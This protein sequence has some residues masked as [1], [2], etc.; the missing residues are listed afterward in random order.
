MHHHHNEDIEDYDRYR[1]WKHEHGYG[2]DDESDLV[3]DEF[4]REE[5]HKR[6]HELHH[7]PAEEHPVEEPEIVP[8]P[9][10]EPEPE[11]EPD[12][13]EDAFNRDPLCE[14]KFGWWRGLVEPLN[15]N[16]KSIEK[17]KQEKAEER[18][19][20]INNSINQ[21]FFDNKYKKYDRGA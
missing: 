7:M 11:S 19:E 13:Y 9:E 17:I 20:A 8:E 18:K 21:N 12:P 3:M 5:R 14:K 6:E 15:P 2:E 10:P 4:E 16:F 1:R